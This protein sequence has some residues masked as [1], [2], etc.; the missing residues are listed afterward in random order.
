MSS[1][2]HLTI[3]RSLLALGGIVLTAV[4]RV[5]MNEGCAVRGSSPQ[6]TDAVKAKV[7]SV[8]YSCIAYHGVCVCDPELLQLES[9]Y[10]VPVL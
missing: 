2:S 3:G 6:P 1:L 4:V 7:R 10:Q 8:A 5:K 9:R